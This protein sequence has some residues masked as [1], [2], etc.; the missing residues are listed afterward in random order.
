[1]VAELDFE[2]IYKTYPRKV[3]K[4]A[5]SKICRRTIKTLEDLDL[6]TKAIANY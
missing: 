6:L 2:S 5:V 3:G 4:S 1:M